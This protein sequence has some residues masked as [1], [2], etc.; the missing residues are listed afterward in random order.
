[1][2]QNYNFVQGLFSQVMNGKNE[3]LATKKS[4]S[5]KGLLSLI[6]LALFASVSMQ[7]QTT[8]IS[9]TGDGGFQTG[10]TFAA[11]GWTNSSSA[12]NPWIIGTAVT[13]APFSGNS[14][15]ISNNGVANAYTDINNSSNFFWR[16]VTV[17]AGETAITLS[18]N[19]IC[20]GE[21][22]WDNW[23]VFY[24]PT[25]VVPTGSTTHPGSGATNVPAGIAGATWLGNGNLQGTVQTATIYLPASLAGTTFRLIFHWKNYFY[26]RCVHF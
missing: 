4:T 6:V 14:A 8:L 13:S 5:F 23:Q 10:S 12:N 2:N 25:T 1:M 9:P 11:N 21:S 15:Y 16:D 3:A 7:G 18:F 26:Y 19:W 22:T 24:A 17:P 20:Q